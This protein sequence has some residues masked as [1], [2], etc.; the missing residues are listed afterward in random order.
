MLSRVR[1]VAWFAGYIP[2]SISR[3]DSA[4]I[5]LLGAS[6]HY[7][8]VASGVAQALF[9]DFNGTLSDDESVLYEVYAE[10]A[11]A[12]GLQL[13]HEQYVEECAG[14]SDLEIF[15]GLFASGESIEVLLVERI[16][17]YARAAGAG[18][19]IPVAARQAMKHAAERVP[20][21]VVTSAFRVEVEPVLAGAGLSP[22]V[23]ALVCADDVA[24]LKPAPEC[25]L[26]ACD[27]L[28]VAPEDSVAIEDSEA[29][30]AAAKGAGLRCAAVTTTMPASRLGAA[31]VLLERFDVEGLDRLLDHRAY[32]N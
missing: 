24:L 21:A 3:Q 7:W 8:G 14:R 28:G 29:G 12:R 4:D 10:M 31:D 15:D 11:S 17:R 20:I 5:T 26:R 22:Y 9:V 1:K 6:L 27:L 13:S 30:V 32:A 19:T 2:V 18:S 23:S 16:A 25:Y